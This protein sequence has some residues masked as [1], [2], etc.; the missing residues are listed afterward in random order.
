MKISIT[1]DVGTEVDV[2]EGYSVFL[3]LDNGNSVYIFE[4]ES[5]TIQIENTTRN[6]DEPG[7]V[8]EPI[9]RSILNITPMAH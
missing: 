3:E 6:I 2:Q 7:F 8:F 1:K 4:V 5:G 9:R